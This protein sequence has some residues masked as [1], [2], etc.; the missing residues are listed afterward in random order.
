[1]ALNL[2]LARWDSSDTQWVSSVRLKAS[3]QDKDQGEGG[4]GAHVWDIMLL[5]S[6]NCKHKG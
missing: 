5:S 2:V 3:Q 6:D 4:G 1:M